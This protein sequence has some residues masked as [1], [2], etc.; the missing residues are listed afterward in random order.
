M[1]RDENG[2]IVVETIG[3]FVP[4]ILLV[5]SILSLVNIVTVQAR[6][7]YALTQTANTVSMY[8]YV[9]ELTGLAN[10]LTTISN[11]AQRTV[12][13]ANE[14]KS[15]INAV[16]DGLEA[17]SDVGD[18]L[19]KGE[20]ATNQVIGAFKDPKAVIQ[21]IMNYGLA[22]LRNK[23]FEELARPLVG[24]YLSNGEMKGDEYLQWAGVVKTDTNGGIVNS[25]LQAL[26]FFQVTNWGTG[27]SVLIDGKGNIKLVVEYEILYTFG[28][29]K[30]PFEPTLHITQTVI[31]KAWLNGSG[32]GYE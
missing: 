11:K 22:E 23:A 12:D 4:F 8:S 31:T 9:F 13:S 6:I 18:A 29:L 32:K 7:H 19:E 1:I 2:Y 10:D 5:V 27:D 15:N 26:E 24:R 3:A 30:L 20:A 17:F 25:G 14:F 16:F 28:G 21:H